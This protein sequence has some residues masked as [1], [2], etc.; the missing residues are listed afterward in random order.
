MPGARGETIITAGGREI[1]V[2]FTNRAL[3]NLE[4]RLG[5]PVL[6]L[7]QAFQTDGAL[8]IG[9]LVQMLRAGMVAAK[10][11]AGESAATTIDE[12]YSVL[13]SAGFAAVVGAVVEAIA[14]VLAYEGDE[15]PDPNS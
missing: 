6:Q 4:T 5:R 15:E 8:G 7:L 2:L 1:H 13:D 10:R 9:D 14:T 3:A 12:A 11:D